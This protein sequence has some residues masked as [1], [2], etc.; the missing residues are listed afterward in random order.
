M[1]CQL[2][3]ISTG[4]TA[5]IGSCYV[6]RTSYAGIHPC[7]SMLGDAYVALLV[8]VMKDSCLM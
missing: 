2:C 5:S 8:K 4:T 6:I 1:Y 7:S 3:C